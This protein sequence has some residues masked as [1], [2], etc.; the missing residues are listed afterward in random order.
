MEE[1]NISTFILFLNIKLLGLFELKVLIGFLN[2][3]IKSLIKV[4]PVDVVDDFFYNAD[5]LTGDHEVNSQAEDGN[6]L[7]SFCQKTLF[8]I[9]LLHQLLV[10]FLILL[11]FLYQC[12]LLIN[13]LQSLFNILVELSLFFHFQTKLHQVSEPVSQ[14]P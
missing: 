3:S 8:L 10:L 2:Y 7:V 11:H 5:E 14:I 12:V 1:Q 9:D 4:S 6:C 13:Q